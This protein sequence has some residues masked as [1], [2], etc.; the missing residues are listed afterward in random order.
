MKLFV[1]FGQRKCDYPGQ[2]AME[3]LACMD[4]NGQSDNPDY[5][6]GE[7]AKYEQSGEFD[8]LSI[9]ELSVSEKDVRNVLYPENTA[10]P[11]TVVQAD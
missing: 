1:L 9:V 11:A 4:E 2:Y 7:H 5:L 6:E 8:R 10:I 3:A